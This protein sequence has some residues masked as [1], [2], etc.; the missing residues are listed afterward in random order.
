[1][2]PYS[3]QVQLCDE[4]GPKILHNQKNVFFLRICS[5]FTQTVSGT[6]SAYV[7]RL[8]YRHILFS[9]MVTWIVVFVR[10]FRSC[11]Q[12]EWGT[13]LILTK[14]NVGTLL[15]NI[16]YTPK[17]EKMVLGSIFC[18]EYYFKRNLGYD[19][20]RSCFV[21]YAPF[22]GNAHA[23]AAQSE[24][25]LECQARYYTDLPLIGLN[26]GPRGL[27]LATSVSGI[28]PPEVV[29]T[30][31]TL[32]NHKCSFLPERQ[33]ARCAWSCVRCWTIICVI[34][35]LESSYWPSHFHGV[36][37]VNLLWHGV[38]HGLCECV[39]LSWQAMRGVCGLQCCLGP[40]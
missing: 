19:S 24:I 39:V 30:L 40:W 36:S 16:V 4:A 9:I 37:V 11:F 23:F 22:K 1:M 28:S 15:W 33:I 26:P 29:Q 3:V 34:L 17:V 12:N 38:C 27:L 21:G 5:L 25:T 20:I 13:M 32:Y 18:V 8:I 31:H 35:L 7:G 10:S 14:Q 2:W 6:Y